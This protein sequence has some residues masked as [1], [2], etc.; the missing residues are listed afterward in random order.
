MPHGMVSTWPYTPD[1]ASASA[2]YR[3]VI[4]ATPTDCFLA[5]KCAKGSPNLQGRCRFAQPK[6]WWRTLPDFL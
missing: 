6:W 5:A 2:L 4:L 3:S 1:W